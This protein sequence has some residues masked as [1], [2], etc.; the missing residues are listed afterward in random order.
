MFQFLQ[1]P[2]RPAAYGAC[3][4]GHQGTFRYPYLL[5]LGLP[6][7]SLRV[8][9][10]L[11]AR[12]LQLPHPRRVLIPQLPHLPSLRVARPQVRL[13]ACILIRPGLV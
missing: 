7:G 11:L 1:R 13:S 2:T 3:L 8:G 10:E 6:G 5:G 9:G 4:K 12:R